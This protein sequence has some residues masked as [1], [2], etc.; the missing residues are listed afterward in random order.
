[1]LRAAS[2]CVAGYPKGDRM[3][4]HAHGLCLLLIRGS[5]LLSFL[6]LVAATSMIAIAY[7]LFVTALL[8]INHDHNEAYNHAKDA[9]KKQLVCV[10]HFRTYL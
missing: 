10:C 6:P 3:K 7:T 9:D 4:A 1:M 5:H 8:N 2:L